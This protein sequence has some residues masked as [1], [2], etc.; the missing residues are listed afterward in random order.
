MRHRIRLPLHVQDAPCLARHLLDLSCR[1]AEISALRAGVLASAA[2]TV[3]TETL[4]NALASL[5]AQAESETDP[6]RRGAIEGCTEA[7]RRIEERSCEPT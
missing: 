7:V 2:E 4:R 5:V 1:V 3:R 6:E